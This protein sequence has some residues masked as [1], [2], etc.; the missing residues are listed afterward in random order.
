MKKITR[1][2]FLKMLNRVLAVTGTAAF[3]APVIAYFYP[4]DL[5][6]MP[7]EPVLAGTIKEIPVGESR[8]IRFGR[9]PAIIINTDA[10]LRA[11][12]AVCTHFACIVKWDAEGDQLYCPCHDGYFAPE[13]GA[14]ISGPPPSALES[15]KV[16]VIGE[17]IYVGGSA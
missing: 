7:S 15:L 4:A 8:T 3:I 2:T 12:S 13:D 11:Y 1:R 10:G 9:Y 17:D 16:E 5:E 14:V 6:E